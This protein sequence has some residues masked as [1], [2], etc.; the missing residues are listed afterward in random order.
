MSRF[1]EIAL[2]GGLAAA[3]AAGPALAQGLGLGRAALPEEVAAWDID[4]RPDGL[5][6]PEGSGSV[7]D[8]EELYDSQCAHCHGTFGEA[9]G[10]WPQLAGGQGTLTDE[11][12]VKTI[13]SYWPY[14]STVWDYVNRSM[15]YGNAQSLSADEVYALTAYL[16]YLNDL[17]DDDFELSHE[18]FAEIRLPNEG[19]F[20]LDDRKALEWPA[21]TATPCM[22]D[23]KPEVEISMRAAVLDVTPEDPTA[24]ARRAIYEAMA[25]ASGTVRAVATPQDGATPAEP[26]AAEAEAEP[27][28]A[29]P[30]YTPEM[31]AAGEAAFRACR[32]CH[33]VGENAR[34][35]TGPVLNGVYGQPAGLVE[36]FRYSPVLTKAGEEGLVWDAEALDAF[37][38]NPRT[39]LPRNRMAYGGMRKDEDRAALIAYLSTFAQ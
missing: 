16:L 32:A 19:G 34:N 4:I 26:A 22:S 39:F 36:G 15:P 3:L 35:G 33:Q 29:A 14:L 18:N 30:A 21:F 27:E 38:A 17:V 12:P 28:A 9:V 1:L 2:A 6:L 31:I 10:G 13:G 37:L 24:A 20:Y 5:G 11:H 8:G 23:C 7:F 25:A